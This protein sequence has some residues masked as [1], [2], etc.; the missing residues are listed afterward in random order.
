[1]AEQLTTE[2]EQQFSY[3]WYAA[4]Q[5]ILEDRYADAL[6][7][8]E[9]CDAI[10]PSDGTTLEALGVVY[11]AL[12]QNDKALDL[13]CRAF[14]AA[15]RDQ[16][17]RYSAALLDKK[18]D[19]ARREALRVLETAY[20]GE[21]RKAKVSTDES[22]LE[23]LMRLYMSEEQWKDALR[24]QDELDRI[25]GYDVYSAYRRARIFTAM[26]K[27]K[28]ALVEINKYLEQDPTNVQF[29]LYRIDLMTRM[30]AK[31]AELFNQ[32]E[33]ILAME[34]YDM[35]IL[36]NYAY[37]LATHGGDLKKA[38]RLSQMTIQKEPDNAVFLDTYG[39]ILYLQGQKQLATF[40]LNKALMN[41]S[42]KSVKIEILRH[43][44]AIK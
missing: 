41:A 6:V 43:L 34:T 20:K 23:Q 32:Y 22:L 13:W 2:Q 25:K 28:K 16:W 39:W 9:F 4:K 30:N 3:Y 29:R 42:D 11:D 7:L 33:Q 10:N 27:N 24:I 35:T 40:Y 5:A 18:T 44:N 17:Y 26:G 38:E 12:G 19:A 36:N 37:L 8:L 14:E 15:P 21:G 1:M 31:P